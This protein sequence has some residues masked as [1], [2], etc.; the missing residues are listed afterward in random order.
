MGAKTNVTNA[1]NSLPSGHATGGSDRAPHCS[2]LSAIA[3]KN[4]F[5][6][7]DVA[8]IFRDVAEIFKKTP[9]VAE[10]RPVGRYVAKDMSEVGSIPLLKKTLLANG[11]LRGDRITVTGRTIAE[12]LKSVR[13]N[14][15]QD[16]IHPAGKPI[17]LTSGVVGLKGNLAPEGAIV[18][19]AGISD[20][21][22]GGARPNAHRN[23]RRVRSGNISS[24]D[25]SRLCA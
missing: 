7:F 23:I 14:P 5:G 8:E 6:L 4:R 19:V 3:L 12:N 16:V 1:E 2:H 10:L 25:P 9:Y 18:E 22:F 21:R 24:S 13:R 20:Q 17:T 15:R 11:P